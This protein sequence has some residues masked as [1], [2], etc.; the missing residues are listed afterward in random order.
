MQ[1]TIKYILQLHLERH[2]R[3]LDTLI[4][5]LLNVRLWVDIPNRMW[6]NY[7]AVTTSVLHYIL[8]CLYDYNLQVYHKNIKAHEYRTS[9]LGPWYFLP[10]PSQPPPPPPPLLLQLLLL[11]LL[12][13]QLLL[14]LLDNDNMQMKYTI[15][16]K[17]H[18]ILIWCCKQFYLRTP[19]R[20][21]R[22]IQIHN[23]IIITIY[24][25]NAMSF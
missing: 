12:L 23:T 17:C 9:H 25:I 3:E 19:S 8:L 20:H 1:N 18:V 11:L 21:V 15:M 2:N 16:Y 7:P 6:N 5:G 14:L 10:L 22:K 13:L 4:P 24:Y